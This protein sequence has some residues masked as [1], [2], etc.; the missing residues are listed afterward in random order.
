[1]TEQI[2][3]VVVGAGVVG[4]AIATRLSQ[5][6]EV[7]VLESAQT[8]G[9]GVSSRNSEVIHA[10]LYY[11]PGSLKAELCVRGRQ[12]LYQFC[13]DYGVEHRACGKIIV[14]TDDQQANSLTALKERAERNG[15]TDLLWLD[16]AAIIDLEPEIRAQAGLLSPSTGIV[17]SHGLMLALQG[18]AEANGAMIAFRSPLV[19]GEIL[20]DGGIV[21]K[22]GGEAPLEIICRRLIIAAGLGTHRAM[23]HLRGYPSRQTP[24]IHLV[25]G[26]YFSLSGRPPFRHLIYPMPEPGSLG[27]HATLDLAGT[28]KFGP[29]V[30]PVE[31]E[32]YHVDPGRRDQ[33]AQ[34][35]RRYWPGLDENALH[36]DYAGIRPRIT[37]QGV[38]LADFQMF[39][40]K[41]HG[42][43]GLMGLA[44]IESP[45][46]TSSLAIAERVEKL[47]ESPAS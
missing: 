18:I 43:A 44:G 32:D 11:E 6:D 17:D 37:P 31:S 22:V 33:F 2:G 8:I 42:I 25:K 1:M 5:S 14:A 29:D 47:M 46:L 19:G 34:A 10:G 13:R 9:S 12:L 3:T 38:P 16:R 30:E 39:G 36:P 4:L 41:D 27:V 26:N 24:P 21:L 7:L 45:G 15:V 28:V 40:P 23:T 35:I 20:P